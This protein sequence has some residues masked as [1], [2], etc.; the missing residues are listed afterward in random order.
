MEMAY[1]QFLLHRNYEIGDI[2]WYWSTGGIPSLVRQTY[3][4][5]YQL[6]LAILTLGLRNPLHWETSQ[7]KD[8]L[9]FHSKKLGMIRIL[10]QTRRLLVLKTYVYLRDSS[11]KKFQDESMF[12]RIHERLDDM[13]LRGNPEASDHVPPS[14]RQPQC[15]HCKSRDIHESLSLEHTKAACP[16]GELSPAKARKARAEVLVNRRAEPTA[17]LRS[18]VTAAIEANRV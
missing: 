2:E 14:P 17:N 16:F 11:A 3:D 9:Q 1:Q 18:L 5:Y 13:E 4:F 12:E 10:S 8:V 6:L 7:A 15:S